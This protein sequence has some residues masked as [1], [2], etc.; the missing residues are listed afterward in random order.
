MQDSVAASDYIGKDGGP[1]RRTGIQAF[2]ENSDVSIWIRS[3][4]HDT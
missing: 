3:G 2:I 4:Y 1:G